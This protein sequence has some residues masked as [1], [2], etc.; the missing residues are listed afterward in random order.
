MS[1]KKTFSTPSVMPSPIENVMRRA[2]SGK[3][4]R[5]GNPGKF[6]VIKRKT[7]N[8]P[9]IMAKFSNAL[10]TTTT[11]RHSLGK[12]SFFSRLAFSRNTFWPLPVISANSPH[13][14]MPAHR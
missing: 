4:A 2:M 3:M 12:L 13:V 14:S 5:N 6:P 9:K 10:A 8:K 1:R 7:L 11:G